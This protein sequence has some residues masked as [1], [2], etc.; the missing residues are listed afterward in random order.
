MVTTLPAFIHGMYFSDILQQKLEY[1]VYHKCHTKNHDDP[2]VQLQ[3]LHAN[4]YYLLM[5][6]FLK[7]LNKIFNFFG[8]KNLSIVASRSLTQIWLNNWR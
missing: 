6:V 3:I 4:E 1:T 7:V 2:E 8:D 5:D